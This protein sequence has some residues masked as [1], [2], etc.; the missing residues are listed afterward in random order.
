MEVIIDKL[1]PTLDW[2][3]VQALLETTPMSSSLPLVA[4]RPKDFIDSYPI[5]KGD[6]IDLVAKVDNKIVG[7]IHGRQ[8]KKMAF[9]DGQ[10]I[11]V[12][13]IYLGDFRV[14]KSLR[15][16]G[17][18]RQLRQAVTQYCKDHDLKYGWGVV[19]SG[20]HKMMKF[21]QQ[22]SQNAQSVLEYTVASRLLLKKPRAHKD[23][24]YCHYQPNKNDF[25]V[26]AQKL[27]QR[28]FGTIISGSD[29]ENLYQKHPE[30]KFYKRKDQAGISF[31][32][33][34][35][36]Q[37]KQLLLT[38]LPVSIKTIRFI[39]NTGR[40]FTG[41]HAFPKAGQPWK[42]AEVSMLVDTQVNPDFED[43]IVYET[44][45]MGCHTVNI[46]ESGLGK[47]YPVFRFKGP[48][49]RLKLK[50]MSYSIG[51]ETPLRPPDSATVDI[52]LAF[53]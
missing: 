21:Y 48:T 52:D 32:I 28:F 36:M 35:Q 27:S 29:I 38:K 8:E 40:L 45:N 9:K 18:A 3:Q 37:I 22:F 10:W 23:F 12:D 34:N 19:V 20:N 31:A 39:W 30:I 41:A 33:W 5:L 49:Y 47:N 4:T 50:L 16:V 53:V 11:E 2:P 43:F 17:V 25:E 44:F 13:S 24:S 51:D 15:R 1:N 7:F 26:L 6:T 42:S 14:D 46:I